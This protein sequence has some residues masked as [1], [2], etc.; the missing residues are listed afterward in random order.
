MGACVRGRFETQSVSQL[1]SAYRKRALYVSV[2]RL[3][4]NTSKTENGHIPFPAIDVVVNRERMIYTHEN[5]WKHAFKKLY[6]AYYKIV[7]LN[8]LLIVLIFSSSRYC[9]SFFFSPCPLITIA[10]IAV[11]I[12]I[13]QV[14]SSFEQNVR[15]C[16][17]FSTNLCW[18]RQISGRFIKHL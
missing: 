14:K 7:H 2:G 8:I 12:L 13:H 3:V 9:P 4:K 10:N 17:S 16:K 18:T 11:P 1:T 6:K 5:P 15:S